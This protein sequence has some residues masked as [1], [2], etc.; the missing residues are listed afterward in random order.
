MPNYVIKVFPK[1][2]VKFAQEP[3]DAVL[4][5]ISQ[6]LE[7]TPSLLFNK[8]L[9]KPRSGFD[10]TSLEMTDYGVKLTYIVEKELVIPTVEGSI[11]EYQM[12]AIPGKFIFEQG[13]LLISNSSDTLIEKGSNAW[14]ELLFP[15]RSLSP[16]PIDFTKEQFHQIIEASARTVLD[17]SHIETK[18]LDKIQLKAYD[19]RNKAWY[20]EEGFDSENAERFSFIPNLPDSF[21]GKTVICKMYRDGRFVVYQSAKFS[22]DEFEQIQLFLIN[23]IAKTVGSP[24]C[25]FGA[26]E[27]QEKLFT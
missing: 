8:E 10:P 14:A 15:T 27:V 3:K 19:L 18:G 5:K 6:K 1:D 4:K 17:I 26:S 2:S 9:K 20:Q 16:S 13:I 21:K 23:K 22:E 24:L 11:R 7:S 12:I 25:K